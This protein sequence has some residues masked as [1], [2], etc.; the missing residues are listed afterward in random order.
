MNPGN[1]QLGYMSTGRHIQDSDE[2]LGSISILPPSLRLVSYQARELSHE[3]LRPP[4]S[5]VD[6]VTTFYLSTKSISKQH[7]EKHLDFISSVIYSTR[8]KGRDSSEVTS[9]ASSAPPARGI[10]HQL[11]FSSS[12]RNW[13]FRL[14][15][16]IGG[17]RLTFDEIGRH[18][19]VCYNCERSVSHLLLM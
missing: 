6:I 16:L 15:F 18:N 7:K 5:N 14:L 19:I 17:S 4:R 12:S 1:C 13:K 3:A 11:V 8:A 9:L 2:M 10:Y